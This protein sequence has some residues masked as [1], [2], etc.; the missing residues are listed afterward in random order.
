M[1]IEEVGKLLAK[2]ALIEN[3][4]ATNEQIMAWT[5]I[6]R[7]V[8]YEFAN[9]AL[10]KHY[11]GRTESIKPAHIYRGAKELKDENRKIIYERKS[12]TE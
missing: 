9:Q 8:E 7:D 3:K 1:N 2:V 11:Q 10:I 4:Q 5:E 12:I 6:L